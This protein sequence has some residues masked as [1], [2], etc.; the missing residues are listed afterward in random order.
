MIK[1]IITKRIEWLKNVAEAVVRNAIMKEISDSIGDYIRKQNGKKMKEKLKAL[2]DS[3]NLIYRILK[4]I[5]N[6]YDDIYLVLRVN[7]CSLIRDEMEDEVYYDAKGRD[8]IKGLKI[9]ELWGL[10]RGLL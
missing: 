6:I 7:G 4:K 3:L 5:N 8:T 9:K 10:L 2:T 1:A